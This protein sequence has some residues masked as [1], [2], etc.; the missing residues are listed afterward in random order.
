[1]NDRS[2]P[3]L[4]LFKGYIPDLSCPDKDG[5]ATGTCPYCGDPDTFRV[6]LRTGHWVCLP[7]PSQAETAR[8]AN[9]AVSRRE[10]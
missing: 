2:Y 6:N 1:M 4:V 5:W 3:F 8:T 9:S 10:P 7:S